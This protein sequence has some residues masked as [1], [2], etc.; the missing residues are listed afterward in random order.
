MIAWVPVSCCRRSL[1]SRLSGAVAKARTSALA[2]KVRRASSTSSQE[3][4]A[5]SGA[6]SG[7]AA[8]WSAA[9]PD[10]PYGFPERD[11]TVFAAE[12]SGGLQKRWLQDLPRQ[13]GSSTSSAS[14][15]AGSIRVERYLPNKEDFWRSPP[16]E[17]LREIVLHSPYHDAL[18]IIMEHD[19]RF[20][21]ADVMCNAEAPMPHIIYEDF[22]KC[23][24][25]SSRQQPPEE[26]FALPEPVL[27]DLLCW[28]AYHCTLDRFYFTSASALFRKLEQEQ[29]MSSAVHSAWV[30]ICTAAGK[31]EEALAYAAYM[32]AHSIPFDADVFARLMHPSLTPVQQHLQQAPQTSKGI[33]LQRR[34]CH[35][36]SQH[37][38]TMSVAVHAMFVYH[39]L[40]LRHTRKWEVLR[41]AAELFNRR[42]RRARS[43]SGLVVPAS[44]TLAAVSAAESPY[45]V[46]CSRTM[47]LAMSLFCREKG[48]RWGS[49]VAKEMVAFMLDNEEAGCTMADVLFV[50]MRIRRNE[51]TGMLATL[52]RTAFSAEEQEALLRVTYRRARRDPAYAVA[53]PLLRELLAADGVSGAAAGDGGSG[54]D[55]AVD[56]AM[57]HLQ[58]LASSVADYNA[59]AVS[60]TLSISPAVAAGA[61]YRGAG[62][63]CA[64]AAG[65]GAGVDDERCSPTSLSGAMMEQLREEEMPSPPAEIARDLLAAVMAL[66]R[67]S[68]VEAPAAVRGSGDAQ[69]TLNES[70]RAASLAT[71]AA[72]EEDR[73][74]DLYVSLEAMGTPSSLSAWSLQ[75]LQREEEEARLHRQAAN[76]WISPAYVPR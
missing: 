10:I 75:Q 41:G 39:I 56:R 60:S 45:E 62:E 54:S 16:Y 21:F 7:A 14:P 22:M 64:P 28:A 3:T 34:L 5:F 36:M 42:Q 23:L 9:L 25:F 58:K 19:Y 53:G 57:R 71:P 1:A 27:R 11:S 70:S 44:S 43:R 47:Q 26:Q 72:P 67:E 55:E 4:R 50:L 73:L 74:R 17:A 29:H 32:E 33:V 12:R 69:T 46:I 49:R 48:V 35:D 63:R 66:D 52:P 15:N 61:P 76:A 37:H 6:A 24:T 31:L 13:V 8:E 68:V 18:K 30:Y 40:T 59:Y 51:R 2:S 20:L 38:G 65:D